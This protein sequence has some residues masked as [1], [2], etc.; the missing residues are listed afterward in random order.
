MDTEQNIKE[1][2]I[3]RAEILLHYNN[4]LIEQCDNW[5]ATEEKDKNEELRMKNEE[6][7]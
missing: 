4:L 1:N 2:I 3:R 6:F 5:L 7:S